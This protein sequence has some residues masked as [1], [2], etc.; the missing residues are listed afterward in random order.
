MRFTPLTS[1]VFF[2]IKE[3]TA[4]VEATYTIAATDSVTRQIG[5][6]GG[7]CLEG[8][9]LMKLITMAF[10]T[11]GSCSHKHYLLPLNPRFMTSVRPC[12]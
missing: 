8:N 4:V 11:T 2:L 3:R 5:A 7:T 6:A 1:F 9:S 10:R 12:S